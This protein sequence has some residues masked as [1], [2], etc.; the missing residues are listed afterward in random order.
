MRAIECEALGNKGGLRGMLE[1]HAKIVELISRTA[2]AIGQKQL[3]KAIYILQQFGLPFHQIYHFHVHGPHSQEL[4]LQLDELCAFNF[5]RE[6][7]DVPCG[8]IGYQITATGEHFLA[9]YDRLLPDMTGPA[10]RL[11]A[12]NDSTL[13]LA[14]LL[15]YFSRQPGEQ[16]EARIQSIRPQV[17]ERQLA[18][19][20][21]FLHTLAQSIAVDTPVLPNR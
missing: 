21:Q 1:E 8:S 15:L 14:A 17:D 3:Q 12:I 2:G 16:P 9:H 6:V 10:C 7:P 4:A 11:A 20:A 5:L 19:A 18:A 13:E